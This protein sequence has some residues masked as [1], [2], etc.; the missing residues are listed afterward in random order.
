MKVEHAHAQ[1]ISFFSPAFIFFNQFSI[2]KCRQTLSDTTDVTYTGSRCCA[3]ISLPLHPALASGY[4]DETSVS[5][6]ATVAAHEGVASHG[7]LHLDEGQRPHRDLTRT[8]NFE[9][10]L[11]VERHEEILAHE[12]G[13]AHVRQTAQVLQVTPHQDGA[14]ALLPERAVHRQH[15]DMHCGAMRFVERQSFL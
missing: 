10:R 3:T 8:Q 11:L 7:I 13:T 4:R 1:V 15:M 5:S 14:A 6:A 12:H 9:A 2:Y